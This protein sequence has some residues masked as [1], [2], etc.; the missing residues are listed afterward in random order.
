[1][2]LIFLMMAQRKN[3]NALNIWIIRAT[4]SKSII[5]KIYKIQTATAVILC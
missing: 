5:M 2:F 1:M 3:M 4:L